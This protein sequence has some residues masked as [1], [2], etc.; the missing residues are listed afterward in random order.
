MKRVFF[1]TLAVCG[2]LLLH[3]AKIDQKVTITIGDE[4]R[5]YILY[6][7]DNVTDPAPLVLSLHGAGGQCIHKSPFRTDVA[8]REG[9]IVAYPQGKMTPFPGLGGVKAPGWSSYGEENFDTDFLQKVIEDV[10][11]KC[12]VDRNRIYCCG[13]SNGGMM[14]FV[15]ANTCSRLFAA[16]ASIS[17][18][19]INEFHLHHTGSR[20]VPYLHIHG[21]Q[22]SFVKYSLV[23]NIIDN[24]V[25][26]NGANPVPE[27]TV[28][29]GKYT[30]NVY[31]AGEGGFPVIFYEIDTMGHGDFTPDTEAG[32]SAQTMWNFFKQYTLDMPCDKTLR[33]NPRIEAE[34]FRPTD[35]GFVLNDGTTLLSFGG[36][37]NSGANQNVY[38]SLQFITGD[39]NLSFRTRGAEGRSLT[40]KLT[41]LTG[42]Q[43]VVLNKTVT[44]GQE[45]TLPFSVSDGWGEYRLTITTDTPEGIQVE[46]LQIHSTGK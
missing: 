18:Y 28:V 42:E 37:Q 44:S 11:S 3:A 46:G 17:G 7:P 14:T 34:D 45:V 33:W 23:P 31:K 26:H 19:P 29:E 12:S 5:E 1:T 4:T 39:Y 21:K 2:A 22:D 16:Y 27:R 13:F 30:K 36:D 32:S 15:M 8:D 9:C 35:H 25:A 38:R 40:V 20:P 24:M 41:K 43:P 6:V 10:C